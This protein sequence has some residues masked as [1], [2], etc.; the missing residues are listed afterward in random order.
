MLLSEVRLRLSYR[1]V[2]LFSNLL[3]SPCLFPLVIYSLVESMFYEGALRVT[4]LG[5]KDVGPTCQ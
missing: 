5:V 2:H 3:T 1:I 4:R